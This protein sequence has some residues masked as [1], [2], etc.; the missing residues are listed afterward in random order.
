MVGPFHDWQTRMARTTFTTLMVLQILAN[1]SSWSNTVIVAQPGGLPLCWLASRARCSQA[2][3]KVA[4][5]RVDVS[6]S[7]KTRV[8]GRVTFRSGVCCM[9]LCREA[10]KLFVLQSIYSY[11]FSLFSPPYDRFTA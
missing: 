3:R 10:R 11:A 7:S 8:V 1:S 2:A 6:E 9:H 4:D 5:M